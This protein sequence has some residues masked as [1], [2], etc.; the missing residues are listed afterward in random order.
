M[1]DIEEL[2]LSTFPKFQSLQTKVYAF[3]PI[4]GSYLLLLAVHLRLFPGSGA[5]LIFFL[6]PVGFP[7][8]I[9][10]VLLFLLP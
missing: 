6:F 9:I 10:L 8:Q 1:I 7:F 2:D 4:P 5:F 3:L